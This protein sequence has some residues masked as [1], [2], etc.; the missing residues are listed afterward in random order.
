M[1]DQPVRSAFRLD[2]L[3]RF[4]ERQRLGLRENVCQQNIVMLSQPVQRLAE[5]D[6]VARD[7]PG[8]LVDQLIKR[9]L[10]IGSRFTPIDRTRLVVRLHSVQR[11]VLAVALH[12]QLLEVGREALQ[13]LLVGKHGDSFGAQEVGVP[14]REQAHQ[15]RQ[16]ALERS[17]AEVL[18][19]CVEAIQH[20]PEVLRTDGDHG[21]KADRRIHRVTSADPVPE[22]EHIGRVDAEPG[23]FRCVGRDRHKMPGDRFFIP[24]KTLNRPGASGVRVGHRFQSREGF[25]RDDEERFGG[26]KI[27]DR[28]GEISTID[29]GHKAECHRALAVGF[30]RF[31]GHHRPEIRAADA[32][33]HNV[34]D[35][36]AG[37]AYPCPAADAVGEVGH[38]VQHLVHVRNDVA[39]IHRNGRPAR[40]PQRRMEHGP[41]FGAVDLLALE[42]GVNPL[43]QAGFVRELQQELHRLAGDAVLRVIEINAR[44]F[45]GQALA[46]LAVI[47]EQI[48]QVQRARLLTM[49]L[50]A[51]P[52]RPLGEPAIGK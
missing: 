44:R 14:D 45:G 48:A 36:L 31:I 26:I 38:P 32:D 20:C 4:A 35:A 23:H 30:Q 9:V 17:R 51:L 50:E 52:G 6:E 39:P 29:V 7:E 22:P 42:H 40:R 41:V 11:D 46:A 33:V 13:I 10:A 49:G 3:G 16:V 24:A 18:V 25:R 28:L 34:A 1:W 2:L 27:P 15:N 43:P 37:M 8:S 19:D 5:R 47:R 21:R 12:R